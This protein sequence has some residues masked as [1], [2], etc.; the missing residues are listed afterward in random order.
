MP[1]K[2]AFFLWLLS[3]PVLVSACTE[4]GDEQ[5]Q[6]SAPPPTAVR[7][8]TVEPQDVPLQQEYPGRLSPV[9]LAEV[10]AR[11]SGIVLARTFT[12]GGDVEAGEVLFEIDP[13]KFEAAVESAKAQIYRAEAAL[14]LA[15]QQFSRIKGLVGKK[16]ASEGQLDAAVAEQRQADA[17]V[18]VAKAN[19]RTAE[20]E[21]SYASVRSPIAGRIG[22]ALVTEGALVRQEDGTKMATVRDLSS[23]YVDFTAP[24]GDIAGLSV[25]GEKGGEPGPDVGTAV[26]LVGDDGSVSP[27]RGKLLFS[28][29]VVDET[30]GQVSIRAEFPNAD[31]QLL[32][33]TYVRVR[34]TQGIE[35]QAL[36]VPRQAVSWDTLG[37]A[38][39][40]LVVDGKAVQQPVVT[41][42]SVGGDWLIS[43]GVASGDQVIV[44]GYERA[45]PGMPVAAEPAKDDGAEE[46]PVE[47]SCSPACNAAN[48]A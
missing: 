46:T 7:T 22:P 17:E 48:K 39:V 28:S 1:R 47:S 21:L 45:R 32:P 25:V 33:G 12:E 29:A 11:V 37:Q 44:E 40:K 10:R 26:E 20:L 43:E 38:S 9:R 5:Q 8:V 14:A 15:T 27:Q 35:R 19:L 24:L 3:I 6:A 36:L 2:I 41:K 18:K 13:A 23:V 34:L 4:S 16:V 30:T 31:R 42:R